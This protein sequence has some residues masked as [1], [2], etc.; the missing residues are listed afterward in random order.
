MTRSTAE[1]QRNTKK[2]YYIG[3]L[4]SFLLVSYLF[5][6]FCDS[7]CNVFCFPFYFNPTVTKRGYRC[8]LFGL[9]NT[10]LWDLLFS[11][12]F[13]DGHWVMPQRSHSWPSPW[14]QQG[15]SPTYMPRAARGQEKVPAGTDPQQ[16]WT[17]TT[18]TPGI[19]PR[20]SCKEGLV[21]GHVSPRVNGHCLQE[22]PMWLSSTA[23]SPGVLWEKD[24]SDEDTGLVVE[25]NRTL[26]TGYPLRAVWMELTNYVASPVLLLSS[27]GTQHTSLEYTL[28]WLVFSPD[29]CLLS[30]R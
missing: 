21:H 30:L 23:P 18:S 10:G 29:T 12:H 11:W 20:G 6:T 9:E 8:Y 5:S 25:A 7:L 16:I 14:S 24:H 2:F 22:A 4:R 1:E 26:Q 27:K 19:P 15:C 17:K 3:S 13:S 28:L